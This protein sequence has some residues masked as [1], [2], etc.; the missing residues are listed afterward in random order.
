MG[1]F[2]LFR[3]KWRHSDSEVRAEAVRQLGPDDL[4]TLTEVARHDPDARVRRIAVKKL[5]DPEVLG[6]LA[7][8]DA[9]EALRAAADD[10]AVE[11]L[12]ARAVGAG[13]GAIAALEQ[14]SR[15]RDVA[16]VAKQAAQAA[17]RKAALA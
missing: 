6:E 13:A 8:T 4:A 11:I 10:K 15:P 1:F 7:R 3:P 14:L 17:V 9:D 5:D 2:D 12:T 16:D